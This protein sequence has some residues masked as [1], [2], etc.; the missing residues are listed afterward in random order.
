MYFP[1]R[2]MVMDLQ[3]RT[4]VPILLLLFNAF[5]LDPDP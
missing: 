4:L 2:S 5:L 3:F 1:K